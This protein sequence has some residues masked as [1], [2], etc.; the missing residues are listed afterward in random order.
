[1]ALANPR[2]RISPSNISRVVLAGV[3]IDGESHVWIAHG[4]AAGASKCEPWSICRVVCPPCYEATAG[5]SVANCV[6]VVGANLINMKMVGARTAPGICLIVV[7]CDGRA[8]A[9]T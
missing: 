4:G 3:I 5:A 9:A 7:Q 6:Q 1:M 8:A 2:R